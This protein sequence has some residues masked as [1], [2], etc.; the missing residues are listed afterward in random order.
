MMG[1]PW[2]VSCGLGWGDLAGVGS[3]TVCCGPSSKLQLCLLRGSSP[4]P[5][6]STGSF[7]ILCT[8]RCCPGCVSSPPP[9]S[10]FPEVKHLKK[11]QPDQGFNLLQEP[12]AIPVCS[13]GEEQDPV[14]RGAPSRGLHLCLLPQ[15]VGTG[16]QCAGQ[17]RPSPA[18]TEKM[19]F[20][21]KCTLLIY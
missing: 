18:R 10:L 19:I 2:W 5:A 15:R 21:N 9:P 17:C 8:F 16:E 13:D 1:A 4:L 6:G 12:D 20:N 14:V 7:P 11:P 3:A